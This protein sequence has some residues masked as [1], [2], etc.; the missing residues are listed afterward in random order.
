MI[1]GRTIEQYE[2]YQKRAEAEK[3]AGNAYSG[4]QGPAVAQRNEGN[5]VRELRVM[6]QNISMLAISL[7]SMREKLSPIIAPRP[8]KEA[9]RGLDTSGATSSVAATLSMFND[10]LLNHIARLQ[11]MTQEVDL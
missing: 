2:Q 5:V 11:Q 1:Q 7:D 9:T 8:E 4:L 10:Q 6:E 3:Q